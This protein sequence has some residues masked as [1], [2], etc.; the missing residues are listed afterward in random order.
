MKKDTE[1][2][3][4]ISKYDLSTARAMMRS[5]RYLYVLFMCQQT[6]EKTLKGLIV[7]IK[8]IFPPKSHDLLKLANI[9]EIDI[10]NSIQKLLSELSYYYIETR[11]PE[12]IININK[13]V[14]KKK[15]GEYLSK[16]EELFK[17]L[18]QKLK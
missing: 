11:Y 13:K 6:I 18:N 1:Y 15:A 16:T 12:D 8:D 4:K 7:E 5:G 17:W 2:W 10:D 14:T 9:T 3:I